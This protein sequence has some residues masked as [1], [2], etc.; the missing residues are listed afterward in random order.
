[1]DANKSF[2]VL[3][4]FFFCQKTKVLM[5]ETEGWQYCDYYEEVNKKGPHRGLFC[6]I[7]FSIAN[8]C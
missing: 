6:K 8:C 2:T 5:N 1:M 4:W 3:S 7:I